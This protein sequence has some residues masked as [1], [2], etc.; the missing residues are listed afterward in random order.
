M[1]S[2]LAS[3]RRRQYH[4]DT[5]RGILDAAEALLVEEGLE[6]FSMRR[7]AGR[8][9]CTA[10]TL[11]HYF[12]DKP[13]LVA[14]LLEERLERLVKELRRVAR[15]D[16]AVEDVLTL[17]AAFAR[18]GLRHPSHYRLL[19]MPRGSELPDPP[20]GEEARR[21]LGEP[22]E[23]LVR[24]GD[25]PEASL[26]TLRQGLW[27]LLHGFVLLQTTRPDEAWEPGLLEASL[28]AMIRGTLA[29]AAAEG[30]R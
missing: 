11:Y 7:L 13:T 27:L 2:D 23:A 5:R 14:V 29:L 19:V 15:S 25:L 21:L 22:L 9:G 30:A 24:R 4:A 28:G 17:T 18:W 12:R 6:S 8:C 26:E 10:P 3:D 20:A 16:D 1:A